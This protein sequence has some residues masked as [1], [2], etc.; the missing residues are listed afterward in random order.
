MTNTLK[1][2]RAQSGFTLAELLIA[3]AIVGLVLAGTFIA[4]R[5]GQDAYAYGVGKVEVQETGRAGVDRMVHDLRTASNIIAA[6][7]TSINFQFID[8][9][10]AT[11]TVTYSL[12]GTNLQR[13]QTNPVPAGAQPE[14]IVGGVNTLDLRY[15][16]GNNN[17]TV[18]VTAIRSVDIRLITR[19][20]A[21]GLASYNLANQQA[22]FEDRVRPRNL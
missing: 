9:T 13:N 4:L 17:V 10:G 15:L 8:E 21:T 12:T 20:Q 16:D 7:Q 18:T 14:T 5:H 19:P 6:T 3:C 22:T 1:A 2:L 11:V